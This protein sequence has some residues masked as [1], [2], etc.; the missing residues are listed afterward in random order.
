MRSVKNKLS[1]LQH[2]LK[3]HWIALLEYFSTGV[4]LKDSLYCGGAFF[5]APVPLLL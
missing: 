3:Q 2:N 4:E 5:S 1:K